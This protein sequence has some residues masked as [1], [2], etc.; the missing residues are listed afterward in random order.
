MSILFKMKH[1][2]WKFQ[3][4]QFFYFY[5]LDVDTNLKRNNYCLL[6]KI[7]QEKYGKFKQITNIDN[8]FMILFKNM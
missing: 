8:S 5:V 1:L 4:K 3:I 2:T 7:I 6:N